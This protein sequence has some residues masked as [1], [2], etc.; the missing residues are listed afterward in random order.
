MSFAEASAA[1]ARR[2]L[3]TVV[4]VDNLAQFQPSVA[5]EISEESAETEVL[6]A[7][8]D[9]D[10]VDVEERAQHSADIS[11]SDAKL[12][13]S[14]ITAAFAAQ[15]LIC[16]IL[17][18]TKDN[19]QENAAISASER[20]D[21][22][23]LDWEILDVGEL[24]TAIARELIIKDEK[25]GGRLRLIAIYTGRSNL[26]DVRS[27]FKKHYDAM[28]K[29]A[30]E[31]GEA[32]APRLVLPKAEITISVGQAKIIFLA[33]GEPAEGNPDR[34][35]T[36]SED[37]L[38]D[39][40]VDEFANFAGGLLSNATL[41][42][43]AELRKH[44]HRMLARFDKS[45]DSAILTHRALVSNKDDA[46]EFIAGLILSELE[47]QVPLKHI[48]KEFVGSDSVRALFQRN[49]ANGRAPALMLDVAGDKLQNLDINLACNVVENGMSA[50]AE[51]HI[52]TQAAAAG[53]ELGK[54]KDVLSKNF[55]KRL[56]ALSADVRDGK[57]GHERFATVSMMRRDLN[58]VKE[59]SNDN[60]PTL[61]LGTI[62]TNGSLYWICLTPLCD[63]V[64]L[65]PNKATLLF[66]QLHKDNSTFEFVVPTNTGSVKLRTKTKEM[67]LVTLNFLNV[68]GGVVRAKLSEGRPVFS[69]FHLNSK[70]EDAENYSWI[71]EL[72]PMQ[73]QRLVQNFASNIARVG[74]DESEWHRLHNPYN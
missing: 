32:K 38:A 15:G 50:F 22:L 55:H 54:Y 51:E 44:T 5:E 46:D 34:H 28:D 58:S 23:V 45:L 20:A 59:W 4:V 74:L 56:Y 60:R 71:G 52:S 41:A 37:K 39:R 1:A 69:A 35:L 9:F 21:I 48:A 13:A 62:L 49:E 7:P 40:L 3:Q 11:H 16:G 26:S 64:R 73:A 6:T 42:S 18:P 19:P 27:S 33:K 65:E 12:D 70:K 57:A 61:K 31:N 53:I 67:H 72:K 25:A 24:A 30:V 29:I 17:K 10:T 47:S 8:D 43:I 14:A 36:V 63:S 66:T 68:E 2:F